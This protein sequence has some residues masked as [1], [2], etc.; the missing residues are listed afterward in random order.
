M[1]KVCRTAGSADIKCLKSWKKQKNSMHDWTQTRTQDFTSLLAYHKY[2]KVFTSI[3]LYIKAEKF[4]LEEWRAS[5]YSAYKEVLWTPLATE[6]LLTLATHIYLFTMYVYY[7]DT[8][9]IH[10]VSQR[11]TCVWW[12]WINQVL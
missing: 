12:T 8:I 9:F 5:I 4:S 11:I 3:S 2:C 6:Q 1:L 10:C 7:A